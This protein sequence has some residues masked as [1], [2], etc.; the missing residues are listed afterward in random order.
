MVRG[1]VL[2][3][4]LQRRIADQQRRVGVCLAERHLLRLRQQHLVSTTDVALS[5]VTATERDAAER[6]P[7]DELDRVDSPFGRDAQPR[8]QA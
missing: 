7:R 3:R 5:G 8:Q 6:Q 4:A 1:R 2:E